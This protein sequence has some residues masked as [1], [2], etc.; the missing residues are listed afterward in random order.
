MSVS[1]KV[2]CID[3]NDKKISISRRCELLQLPRSSYYRP[4]DFHI[5]DE[6]NLELMR[7]IDEEFLRHPFYGSRKMK[8]Y[9]NREGYPVNHKRVQLLMTL[10]GLES[11]AP[12]PNTSRQ[13]KEHKVYPYL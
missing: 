9:L 12:K 10:I 13:R 2:K 4:R 7:L 1:E 6:E 3:G 5:E 11:I 8:D